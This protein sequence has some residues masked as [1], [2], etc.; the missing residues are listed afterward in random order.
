[1]S[2]FYLSLAAAVLWAVV[3]IAEKKSCIGEKPI[4]ASVASTSIWG[5]L[6]LLLIPYIN[7][8]HDLRIL[9]LM[10]VAG[11]VFGISYY[12]SAK[13]FKYLS[14]SEVSPLYNF[15]TIITVVLAVV[16]L[17]E[18]L[19]GLQVVGI[20]T[21]VFGTYFLE[22]KKGSPLA[23]LQKIFASEKIHY[24]IFSTIGYSILAVL[25]KYILGFVDPITYIFS[26]LFISGAFVF[27]LSMFKGLSV[28]N[29]ISGIR[30]HRLAILIIAI[31]MFVA[32]I[33]E[34]LA[35]ADGEASLV[36]PIIRCW[37]LLA[38]VFGGAFFREGRMKNK[39]IASIIMLIGVFIIY[40]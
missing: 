14:A 9:L 24:V 38:T 23:P 19:T 36:M 32:Q 33:F 31:S 11:A 26:Q 37:T 40:L 35:F 28:K 30:G 39:I 3:A 8:P 6:S 20:L 25:S 22:M 12:L 21:I 29:I 17:H 16:L 13:A 5:I 10:L 4:L 7:I 27:L 18:K 2:W 15:G 1:M 34:I